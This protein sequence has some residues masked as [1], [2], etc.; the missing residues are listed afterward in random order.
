MYSSVSSPVLLAGLLASTAVMAS[1]QS[2]DDLLSLPLEQLMN[3]KVQV[4]TRGDNR[5]GDHK[6]PVDIVSADELR[7]SGYGDLPKVLNHLV[8]SF[9][10]D[11]STIDDL[12]DHVRPFS[13][14]GLKA[15]QVL[16]LINGRRVHTSAILDAADSQNRG[17]ATV[18]LSLI[19]LESIKQVEILRDDAS[20][21]YG[22]DAMA[23]VINIVLKDQGP[24]ES[25][26]TLG[27][28]QAGDGQ[29]EQA[30]YNYGQDKLFVS[31]EL[32]HKEHSNTSGLDRRDYYFP[33]D[34]RNGDYNVTHRYGD[35]DA[36]SV[37][38][39]FNSQEL[40][41]QEHFYAIGRLVYK[42]SE[43]AGFFRLP[44]DDR[45][46]RA[47]YPDGFLPLLAPTQQDL[48]TSIGYRNSDESSS[49]DISNTLGYNQAD[50][51]VLHSLNASLGAASPT[52]FDAGQLSF[53]QNSV[54]VDATQKFIVRGY[55]VFN[56]AY[57]AELR[58]EK[59][60]IK[61][62]EPSSWEDGSVPVL[63]GP[64]AGAITVAGAQLYPGFSPEDA[65]QLSRDVAAVYGELSH[66][67]SKKFDATASLRDEH[68]SDFGDTLNGKL[69][70]H[71]QPLNTVNVR[72]SVSTGYRAPSLQQMGYYRTATSFAVQPDGSIVG[73]ETGTF[74]VTNPVAKLLGAQ[75]LTPEQSVRRNLGFSWEASPSLQFNLDY[76][77]IGIKDRI[78]LSGAI[79]SDA[80]IPAEAQ[81]YMAAQR[82][83]SASYFLNGVDTSTDGLDASMNY[84]T[85]LA[86]NPLSIK[87]QYH[88]QHSDITRTHF[89]HQLWKLDDEVFDREE[90]ERL[91]HYLPENK[92]LVSIN[93]Q[94][95]QWALFAKANYFGKVIYVS[96]SD[97]TAS[98][99]WFGARMTCDADVSYQVNQRLNLAFGGQNIFNTYP[100]YR[101]SNPPFNGKGNILQFRGISPFDYT[102]AYF[103]LRMRFT[104]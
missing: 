58:H 76:F 61:A 4:G 8:A 22:S 2:F 95:N 102:G 3:V 60:A 47:I 31:I 98:D 80:D 25:V 42:E 69:L 37:S 86:G 23:G 24:T 16:V 101:N 70:L 36:Q 26:V 50:I 35:P 43:A 89:P 1:E 6:I 83:S 5:V 75:P 67:F 29:L 85:R 56:I 49:L 62:G 99:Q 41:N 12:T 14:N 28:R 17:S 55:S 73:A 79:G 40:F 88:Q 64:D 82:I 65:N 100:D 53:G 72:A 97:N 30:S 32:K 68:Y 44:S 7:R 104:L 18:D 59:F 54:N 90:Q 93:Y 78:I 46:V 63:D 9:T 19:P 48:F 57:G 38:L 96:E 71:Y 91:L 39:S 13:L 11:F 81:A 15:D 103:Y 51:H 20:A 34:P 66:A 77:N 21:Q 94:W 10:Y 87:F 84:S 52:R 74:L 33:G 45:N 27:Q 92:S